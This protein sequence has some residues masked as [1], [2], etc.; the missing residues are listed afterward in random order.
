MKGGLTIAVY[1]EDGV[2]IAQGLEHDIC[3]Q[4]GSMAVLRER[5]ACLVELEIAEMAV[6]G[7]PLPPAPTRFHLI[8]DRLTDRPHLA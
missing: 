3:T 4:A 5:M 6:R 1:E 7:C 2:F 8:Q